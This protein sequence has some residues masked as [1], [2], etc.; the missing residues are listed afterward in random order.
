[1]NVF[2]MGLKSDKELEKYLNS[3]VIEKNSLK[4]DNDDTHI[5]RENKYWN[6]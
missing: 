3:G 1:M 4:K 5:E 6:R 2:Q